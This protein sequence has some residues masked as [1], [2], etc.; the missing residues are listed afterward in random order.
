MTIQMEISLRRQRIDD[1]EIEFV[2]I[3][4]LNE[5][6]ENVGMREHE[7]FEVICRPWS[8]SFTIN[9]KNGLDRWEQMSCH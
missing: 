9:N 1:R 6:S 5:P 3:F 4:L 2:L 8:R 7:K